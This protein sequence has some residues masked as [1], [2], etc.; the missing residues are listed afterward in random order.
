[1]NAILP[2]QLFYFCCR[3]GL[4]TSVF[5]YPVLA[6]RYWVI[7]RMKTGLSLLALRC[8]LDHDAGHWEKYVKRRTHHS[9]CDYRFLLF[10]A[11]SWLSSRVSPDV[12][13]WAFFFSLAL[14]AVV[15]PWYNCR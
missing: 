1:V 14:R 11:Y 3:L 13:K 12:G 6:Q 10:A 4:F 2:S 7:R 8:L 9:I 15:S 5:V